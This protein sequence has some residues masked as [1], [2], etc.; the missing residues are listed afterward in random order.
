MALLQN[1]LSPHSEFHCRL[2]DDRFR[3]IVDTH[4]EQ[5]RCNFLLCIGWMVR[6]KSHIRNADCY[7]KRN[8]NLDVGLHG[9]ERERHA[10]SDCSRFCTKPNEYYCD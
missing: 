9:F 7:S 3:S 6:N 4:V 2:C 8:D 1:E 5:Y 10:V